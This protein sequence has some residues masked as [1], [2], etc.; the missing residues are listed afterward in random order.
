MATHRPTRRAVRCSRSRRSRWSGE[1]PDHGAV[2]VSIEGR[3]PGYPRV[4]PPPDLIERNARAVA[5]ELAR[6]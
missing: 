3:C 4:A 1:H 5:A 6:R 2:R